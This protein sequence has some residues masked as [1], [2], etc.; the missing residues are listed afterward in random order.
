VIDYVT[1]EGRIGNRW[2]FRISSWKSL[3]KLESTVCHISGSTNETDDLVKH[4]LSD[5]LSTPLVRLEIN[6]SSRI[7]YPNLSPVKVIF[8][9]LNQCKYNMEHV[10][11]KIFQDAV[12]L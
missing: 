11:E 1:G 6:V 9:P 8:F 12:Q 3:T 4:D 5:L 7:H 2:P 10:L